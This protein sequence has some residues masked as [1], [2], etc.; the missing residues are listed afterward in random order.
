MKLSGSNFYARPSPH[1][2][3]AK[4][5]GKDG[6]GRLGGAHASSRRTPSDTGIAGAGPPASRR[7]GAAREEHR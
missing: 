2:H 1:F 5:W 7:P 6:R 4:T 3:T